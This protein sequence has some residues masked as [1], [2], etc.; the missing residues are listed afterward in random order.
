[1]AYIVELGIYCCQEAVRLNEKRDDSMAVNKE[2]KPKTVP[3]TDQAAMA[4][5]Q[6]VMKQFEKTFEKLAKN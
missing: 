6:S 1:M 2:Q 5:A 4:A 3:V